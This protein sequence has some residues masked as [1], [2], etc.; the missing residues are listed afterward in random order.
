LTLS[1]ITGF[2]STLF[3]CLPLLLIS[4]EQVSRSRV[5]AYNK[6]IYAALNSLIQ[7]QVMI[8]EEN[9]HVQIIIYL[10]WL[11]THSTFL[12]SHV[13]LSSFI[14]KALE[15]FPSSRS[16]SPLPTQIYVFHTYEK[17][18]VSSLSFSQH[19]CLFVL[20]RVKHVTCQQP[21]LI[22]YT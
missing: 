14:P 5:T 19:T 18:T 6:T 4:V 15:S 20:L 12:A 22:Q 17:L 21:R 9:P 1:K 8:N 11:R 10:S 7:L 16:V 13:H 2:K 3:C